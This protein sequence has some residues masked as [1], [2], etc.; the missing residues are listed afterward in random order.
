M[1]RQS[2]V[3]LA[4]SSLPSKYGIGCFDS[5]AYSFVE[6]LARAGQT[7]WQILPLGAT[8]HQGAYDSPYQAY[9]AFAGNPYF[10]SLDALIDE[11]VLTRRECSRARLCTD[12][13]RV[14]YEALS[15]RRLPLLRKAYERSRIYENPA[16][17]EFVC[18]NHWWLEDYA[19]FMALKEHFGGK[20]WLDW[21]EEIR[22]HREEALDPYR[23]EL[24][25]DIEFHRYLQ[26]KFYEQWAKLKQYANSKHIQI[27][28]DLPIYISPDGSDIWASPE[29]FEL[30]SQRRCTRV[31]G[32]PPD[33]FSED[34]QVWGNPLYRWS[35]HRA[36]GYQW[37]VTR[38][39]YSYKLYDV[40]RL[41]HFRGFDEYFAIPAST[42]QAKDG[43]WEQGPGMELF[44]AL[45]A[46]LGDTPIIAED[47]GFMTDSVRKLVLSSGYPNMKVL[48]FAFDA[49]DRGGANEYLPHNYPNNCVVYT[50]THDNDTTAGWF[51]AQS[52]EAK[53][54]IRAYLGAGKEADREMY[55]LLL[56]LAIGSA[57]KICI[58]PIQ[59]WLGLDSTA[60]MNAPGT[61]GT[62]W[63]WRL[64]RDMLTDSLLQD[65]LTLTKRYGRANWD[66]LMQD[67]E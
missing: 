14:D 20:C 47:L 3:L 42:M 31:A 2:G 5:A 39:W 22:T 44:D 21:P 62:N 9:S 37:W 40:I 1:K 19:L 16:Y 59:D 60:R 51:A 30:D 29:L 67:E 33:S 35:Y 52:S 11:G 43:R 17:L 54:Y 49:S 28:G 7:Y 18:E 46:Q 26:F 25:F 65:M 10:I 23:R 50:G 45:R 34:G 41:D 6:F 57:A 55:K 8:S 61:V 32:C 12:P 13:G 53:A 63:A 56:R 58:I 15:K 38:M 36:T 27:V 64:T 48:Q 4:I 24:Y 66:A